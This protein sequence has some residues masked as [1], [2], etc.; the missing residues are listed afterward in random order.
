[1]IHLKCQ[2]LWIEWCKFQTF[3]LNFFQLWPQIDEMIVWER[4]QDKTRCP[5]TAFQLYQS[6]EATV[7]LE[8]AAWMALAIDSGQNLCSEDPL[9]ELLELG[10][11]LPDTVFNFLLD[12]LVPPAPFLEPLFERFEF[13][14]ESELAESNMGCNIRL[15]ALM[16]QLLTCSKVSEVCAAMARF[17]SSVGYGCWTI[18]RSIMS[19]WYLNGDNEQAH[20]QG[21]ESEKTRR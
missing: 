6:L 5:S 13:S 3:R 2:W 15:R 20:S 8:L 11:E 16:N 4:D 17:S 18:Y 21:E 19:S 7:R 1:M 10:V 12:P 9:L 14:F